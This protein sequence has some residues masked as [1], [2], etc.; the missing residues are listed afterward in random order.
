[1]VGSSGSDAGRAMAL[2]TAEGLI[3]VDTRHTRDVFA[4]LTSWGLPALT[5]HYGGT[6]D[7]D[8]QAD[9]VL[10]DAPRRIR[11]MS[12]TTTTTDRTRTHGLITKEL[13]TVRFTTTTLGEAFE[14]SDHA[15]VTLRH[16]V[17]DGRD[18]ADLTLDDITSQV[19][20]F[21]GAD[22]YWDREDTQAD[23]DGPVTIVYT[24]ENDVT[25]DVTGNA[26]EYRH[27]ITAER[28]DLARVR[29]HDIAGR[30]GECQCATCANPPDVAQLAREAKAIL[31]LIDSP[32]YDR[33]NTGFVGATVRMRRG[34]ITLADTTDYYAAFVTQT[35]Q[36]GVVLTIAVGNTQ[37]PATAAL[38]GAIERAA[39]AT[40]DYREIARSESMVLLAHQNV[41]FYKVT[42]AN[43]EAING[44]TFTYDLPTRD[45][46]GN[47]T[48]GAWTPSVDTLEMCHRG[49]HLTA[50]VDNWADGSTAF[51]V[52]EAEAR[53]A[54]A[55]F[56]GDKIVAKQVRLL[57]EVDLAE[58]LPRFARAKTWVDTVAVPLL[59]EVAAASGPPK[60]L[61]EWAVADP[62]GTARLQESIYNRLDSLVPRGAWGEGENRARISA[63]VNMATDEP[64]SRAV[65]NVTPAH[66]YARQSGLLDLLQG[67][68]RMV[69]ALD[70]SDW[71][72]PLIGLVRDGWV[73]VGFESR[74]GRVVVRPLR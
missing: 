16:S 12:D 72:D 47:Q 5:H 59:H 35:P 56:S 64:A 28:Q 25:D 3:R 2:G 66:R 54:L 73:P 60:A 6:I 24:A 1:M 37:S 51:R 55:L 49:Y 14:T 63:Y 71:V 43:G 39:L 18:T 52:F 10:R 27:R 21:H 74:Y 48:P 4:H 22:L 40:G 62:S 7:F 8:Q 45:A 36:R 19:F 50:D 15:D 42:G 23:E 61:P 32:G 58:V 65:A 67:A 70:R 57:R 11:P 41:T 38:A 68:A 31:E 29:L 34:E 17:E 46:F 53:E 20:W 26:I 13:W 69:G 30:A 44:G 9:G 33:R